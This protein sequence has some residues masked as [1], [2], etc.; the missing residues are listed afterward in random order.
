[1]VSDTL[2]RVFIHRE[3]PSYYACSINGGLPI[4]IVHM[5][6][7]NIPALLREPGTVGSKGAAERYLQRG[8]AL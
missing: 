2:A 8:V 3:D 1:M 5:C 7:P 6:Q 4:I